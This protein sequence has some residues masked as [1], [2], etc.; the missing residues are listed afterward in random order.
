MVTLVVLITLI[1]LGIFSVNRYDS[2]LGEVGGILLSISAAIGLLFHLIA[3]GLV[4]YNFNQ[5]VAQRDAFELTLNNSREGGNEYE[6]AAIIKE[7]ATWNI[8]LAQMKYDNS[9]LLADQY[10]DDRVEDLEPI[11]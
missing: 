11:K 9:T 3:F 8:Q 5:F 2:F 10:I 4:G 1:A 6:A 7:V